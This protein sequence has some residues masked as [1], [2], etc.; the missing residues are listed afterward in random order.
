MEI[1]ARR[2]QR[3]QP[4]GQETHGRHHPPR[5]HPRPR[6][7]TQ[8]RR[9]LVREKQDGHGQQEHVSRHVMPPAQSRYRTPRALG[10]HQRGCEQPWVRGGRE[11]DFGEAVV[12]W[13]GKGGPRGECDGA[14][15]AREEDDAF[16]QWGAKEPARERE[17]SEGGEDPLAYAREGLRAARAGEPEEEKGKGGPTP[18]AFDEPD[19]EEVGFIGKVVSFVEGVRQVCEEGVRGVEVSVVL[20]GIDSSEE[21]D[22]RKRYKGGLSGIDTDRHD[23]LGPRRNGAASVHD[24]SV[25]RDSV[26]TES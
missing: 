12:V 19:I 21:Q 24:E 1:H 7:G 6:H 23:S 10:E 11:L 26:S 25:S 4:N 8:R 13:D 9:Q 5:M 16:D 17:P 15:A 3:K 2:P 14:F 20:D 18:S 22:K